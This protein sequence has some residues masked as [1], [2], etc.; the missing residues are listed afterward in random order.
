MAGI[1]WHIPDSAVW[2]GDTNL[3]VGGT[4]AADTVYQS[5]GYE[6]DKA[7]DGNIGTRWQ[8]YQYSAMPKWWRYDLGAGNEAAID[9]LRMRGAG[10]FTPKNFNIEGSHT[11]SGDK[12]GT[13]WDILYVAVGINS[14][15]WEEYIFTN[16]TAYRYYRLYITSNQDGAPAGSDVL[17]YELEMMRQYT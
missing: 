4:A 15:G 10:V 5:P 9:K 17:I 11:G 1:F 2:T 12:P 8:C 7:V 3:L 16:N 14:T 13:D 6:A